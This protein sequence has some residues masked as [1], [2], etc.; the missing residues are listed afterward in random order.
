MIMYKIFS[1][2]KTHISDNSQLNSTPLN[3]A[4]LLKELE[5]LE[6]DLGD[7]KLE[8]YPEEEEMDREID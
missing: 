8:D 6:K 2:N 5:T 3:A 1:T 7:K 4:D